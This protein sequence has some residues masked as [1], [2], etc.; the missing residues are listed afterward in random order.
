MRPVLITI[1]SAIT[2]VSCGQTNSPDAGITATSQ[3]APVSS[4][5]SGKESTAT[6]S[7]GCFW[8]SELVFE[9]LVGVRSAVVGYC[10]G[11]TEHPTYESVSTGETGYAESVQVSYDSSKISYKTLVQAFFASHDPTQLDR[12]SVV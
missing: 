8:H 12:K 5:D 7:E 3:V 1:L 10:G 2:L 4:T 9:S 11:V 6:F